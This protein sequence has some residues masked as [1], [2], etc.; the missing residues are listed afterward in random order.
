M[1]SRWRLS[2]TGLRHPAEHKTDD[3]MRLRARIVERQGF[4]SPRDAIIPRRDTGDI[5]VTVG[6]KQ[7]SH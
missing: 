6:R 7:M 5:S 3:N 1:C 2:L 4:R